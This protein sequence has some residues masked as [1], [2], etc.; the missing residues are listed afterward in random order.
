[1]LDPKVMADKLEQLETELKCSEIDLKIARAEADALWKH[2]EWLRGFF[3]V[4]DPEIDATRE[5]V[6]K[7]YHA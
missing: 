3:G 5:D 7:A 2:I 1:M 4:H 6:V